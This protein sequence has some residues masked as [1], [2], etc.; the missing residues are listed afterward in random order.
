MANADIKLKIPSAVFYIDPVRAFIGNLA[1]SLGFSRKRVADIQ[2]V[3]DEICSNAVHHGSIDA[4]VGVKLH[5]RSNAHSLEILVRDTG[6]QHKGQKNWLTHERLSEIEANRSPS[7]E[8]GHGIFIAKS[9]SDTYEMQTNAAGG[10]DVRVVFQL[11]K[12]VDTKP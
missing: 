1:K 2:L 7:N 9:L 11:L 4:T 12:P 5:I 10:T 8:G 6:S 3:I